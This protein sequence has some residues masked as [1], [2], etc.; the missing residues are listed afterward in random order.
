MQKSEFDEYSKDYSRLH[1]GVLG[2]SGESAEFF[3]EY[4]AR[5][6]LREVNRRYAGASGN[7]LDFGCG[8]GG[9]I[10]Y[11]S[12]Y[13]PDWR[14]V[15]ADVSSKSLELARK[16]FGKEVEFVHFEGHCLPF[17]NEQ[18]AVVF[19][20]CVFHHIPPEDHLVLLHEIYRVMNPGGLFIIFEHNP[21]NW[22]TVKAV[23]NC[24]FDENAILI[25]G[26]DCLRKITHT[27]FI[28]PQ[29][30]YRVFFPALLR[31]LRPIER[32]LSWLPLGAQYYVCAE[33]PS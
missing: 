31:W 27:G 2:P 19:T 11:L 14:I 25:R 12:G 26:K 7:I 8:I 16:S 30:K 20:S 32:A 23:N 21:Y 28:N 15:G 1:E 9:S 3:A 10:P 4:K 22:L 18:F 17:E 5:D 13:L 24:P 33:K 29:L 6:T